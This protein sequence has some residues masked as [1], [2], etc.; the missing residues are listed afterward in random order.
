MSKADDI[1][2][3]EFG[4]ILLLLVLFTVCMFILANRIGGD[5]FEAMQNT[6]TAVMERIAPIGQVHI[7]DANQVVAV[8]ASA[9]I[10]C[11][12]IRCDGRRSGRSQWR[13][14]QIARATGGLL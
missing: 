13:L 8:E 11:P 9:S 7:G 12:A 14:C 2:Y 3:R 10:S 6:K 4:V 1:F 5:A